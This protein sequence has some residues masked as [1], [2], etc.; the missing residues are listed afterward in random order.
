MP[1]IYKGS[2]KDKIAHPSRNGVD[3]W[4]LVSTPTMD[5]SA[6]S[7]LVR[8][9]SAPNARATTKVLGAN[10]RLTL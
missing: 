3:E 8:N 4:L 7:Q 10:I 5:D 2:L 6:N 1:N 9:S